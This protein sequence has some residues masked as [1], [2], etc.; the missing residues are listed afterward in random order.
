MKICDEGVHRVNCVVCG[1]EF[2]GYSRRAKYCSVACRKHAQRARGTTSTPK[3][4]RNSYCGESVYR[5]KC[6][7]CGKEFDG[8]SA[9]RKYC[10][11]AC[12]RSAERARKGGSTPKV[13]RRVTCTF[14]G[15]E[16]ETVSPTKKY[17]SSACST[18]HYNASRQNALGKVEVTCTGCGKPYIKRANNQKFCPECQAEHRRAAQAKAHDEIFAHEVTCGIC[19]KKFTAFGKSAKYCS[20]KCK[21]IANNTYR[22][23]REVERLSKQE[24]RERRMAKWIREAR[25]CGMDYGNYR[26][27]IEQF[28]KTYEELKAQA[29]YRSAN[30]NLGSRVHI[31]GR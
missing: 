12:R 24:I 30:Q 31:N 29:E 2:I 17:C 7:V 19:G 11:V 15:K 9:P 4:S 10:S 3:V 14:C 18:K 26:A 27:Q 28:G 22:E 23:R 1:K 25:E 20:D 16:F 6:V 8:Y 21:H 13:P 5:G